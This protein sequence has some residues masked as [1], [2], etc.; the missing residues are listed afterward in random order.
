MA[1]DDVAWLSQIAESQQQTVITLNAILTQMKTGIAL[2]TQL[3]TYAF[4]SLP[5]AATNPALL[6]FVSNGRKPG[7]GAGLGTGMTAFS[8]GTGWFG[9]DGTTLLV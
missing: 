7:E 9:T 8:D 4:A 3:P 5:A 6:V 2:A 1:D